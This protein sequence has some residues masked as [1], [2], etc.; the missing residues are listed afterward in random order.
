MWMHALCWVCSVQAVDAASVAPTC[1]ISVCIDS[2]HRW[3]AALSNR[4]HAGYLGAILFE[5]ELEQPLLGQTLSV[6]SL[7]DLEGATVRALHCGSPPR[8]Q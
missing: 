6:T 8:K 3:H 4:C 7:V 1:F 5:Q 2:S